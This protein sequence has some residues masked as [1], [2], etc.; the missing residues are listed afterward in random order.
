MNHTAS[1]LANRKGAPR[2]CAKWK[3]FLGREGLFREE[4]KEVFNRVDCFRQ[5]YLPLWE[6]WGVCHAE[7]F[8]SADQIIPDSLAK[9]TFLGEAETAIKPWFAVTGAIW[10]LLFLSFFLSLLSQLKQVIKIEGISAPLSYRSGSS[11]RFY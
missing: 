3:G 5:G 8:T 7:Y 10:G 1:R 4:E 2:S 9:V 6:E 11:H